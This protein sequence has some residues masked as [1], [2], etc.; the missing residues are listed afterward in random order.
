MGRRKQNPLLVG[1]CRGC[2]SGDAFSTRALQGTDRGCGPS[3]AQICAAA[4]RRLEGRVYRHLQARDSAHLFEGHV[5]G[6][7]WRGH[8]F[9]GLLMSATL[10]QQVDLQ[11][12]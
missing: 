10:N 5:G 2:G 1:L 3:T 8:Q 4:P 6:E 11:R 12:W 9:E 7:G